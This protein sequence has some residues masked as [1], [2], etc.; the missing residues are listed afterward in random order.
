MEVFIPG[1]FNPSRLNLVQ[2]SSATLD[3]TVEDINLILRRLEEQL[4]ENI[5]LAM[6]NNR[7]C[8]SSDNDR[9][10][11]MLRLRGDKKD[12]HDDGVSILKTISS[13]PIDERPRQRMRKR[14]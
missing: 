11:R 13:L 7:F 9:G 1:I 8:G 2:L 5:G 14:P 3:D 12:N 4:L 6:E 10:S